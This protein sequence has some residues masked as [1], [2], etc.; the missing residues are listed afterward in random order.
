MTKEQ[1]WLALENIEAR[2]PGTWE[3]LVFC[4][5][6]QA[7]S[8]KPLIL[9]NRMKDAM[10]RVWTGVL[11]LDFLGDIKNHDDRVELSHALVEAIL[12]KARDRTDG[13]KAI[14]P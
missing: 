3:E 10:D 1:L 13:K 14:E 2:A 6:K 11:D 4:M 8:L 7:E 12:E 5:G 9:H